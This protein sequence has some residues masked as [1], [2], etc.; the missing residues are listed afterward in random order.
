MFYF[1]VMLKEKLNIANF[2]VKKVTIETFFNYKL[3]KQVTGLYR[4]NFILKLYI[5]FQITY[6]S[7]NK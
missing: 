4:Y 3:K 5:F 6:I 1:K 2:L 7:Y